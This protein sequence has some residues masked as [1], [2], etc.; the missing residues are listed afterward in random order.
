MN[1]HTQGYPILGKYIY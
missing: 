1:K